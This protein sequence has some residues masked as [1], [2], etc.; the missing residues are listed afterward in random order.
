MGLITT[1]QK[2]VLLDE[3]SRIGITRF[4]LDTIPATYKKLLGTPD[5]GMQQY[6][7][8]TAPIYLADFGADVS[9]QRMSKYFSGVYRD[10]RVADQALYDIENKIISFQ[11]SLWARTQLLKNKA[12]TLQKSAAAEQSRSDNNA[13]WSFSD[14]LTDTNWLD[15]SK[16]TAWIDCSEGIAFLPTVGP[17]SSVSSDLISITEQHSSG[18][19]MLGSSADM[20]IDNSDSTNWRAMFTDATQMCSA[21]F[22]FTSALNI[23]AV[24]IDPVGFGINVSID[25]DT[26]TGFTQI[27]SEILYKKTTISTPV[28]A[29]KTIKISFT[30]FGA[31]L[32]KSAGMRSLRFILSGGADS[33]S[34]VTK[35]IGVSVPYSQVLINYDATVPQGARLVPMIS[36]DGLLW[37]TLQAGVWTQVAPS[38]TPRVAIDPTAVSFDSGLYKIKMDSLPESSS[39]GSMQIGADQVEVTAIRHDYTADGDIPHLPLPQDFDDLSTKSFT[40]W[41]GVPYRNA[42]STYPNH[43]YMLPYANQLPAVTRGQN[44]LPFEFQVDGEAYKDFTILPMAGP[45]ADRICQP[46]YSYKIVYNVYAEND[47]VIDNARYWFLQGTRSRVSK[48]FKDAGR[49]Y[50]AF[51]LVINDVM[52]AS[53]SKP[54]TIYVEQDNGSYIEGGAAGMGEAGTRF[55]LSLKQ[56]WNTVS[57]Q[58]HTIDPLFYGADATTPD[59]FAPYLQLSLNPSLF[60]TRVQDLAGVSK[61]VASGTVS[62]VNEFDLLWNTP[63]DR[64]F[65]AWSDEGGYILFNSWGTTIIDGY[66]CGTNPNYVLEYTGLPDAAPEFSQVIARLDLLRDQSTASGPLVNSY[67]IMVK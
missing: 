65:W 55:T 54:Y 58:V 38:S 52:V 39:T 25:A 45:I 24:A 11:Y 44:I 10:L 4:Q 47:Y 5:I 1:T 61:I 62:P 34:I 63:R 50:G 33:A 8:P 49:S 21:V 23:S 40:T 30:S 16:T 9:V 51:S 2:T 27:A 66:I 41:M 35:T 57:I 43:V 7:L 28:S 17:S 12:Q 36:L 37:K 64:R 3:A 15:M 59:G 29:V 6:G 56:G 18:L 22:T 60:D 53:S 42:R 46:N 20:A 26:G 31:V 14:S 32:P 19:D 13:S 67:Q 48:S